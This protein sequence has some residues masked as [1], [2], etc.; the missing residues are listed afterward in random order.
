VRERVRKVAYRARDELDD[1]T[2]AADWIHHADLDVKH[3]R[4]DKKTLEA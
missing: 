3:L 2:T 1:D 4:D